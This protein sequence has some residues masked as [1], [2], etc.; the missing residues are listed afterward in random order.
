MEDGKVTP[1]Q[2]MFSSID[3]NLETEAGDTDDIYDC[4]RRSSLALEDQNASDKK[5]VDSIMLEV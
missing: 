3:I 4:T 2:Y 1:S 5:S